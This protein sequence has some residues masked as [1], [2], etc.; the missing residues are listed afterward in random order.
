MTRADRRAAPGLLAIA[1][2]VGLVGPAPV[3]AQDRSEESCVACHAAIPDERLSVP[4][5]DWSEDVHAA[6]GFGCVACHGGD[7]QEMSLDAMDPEHGYIG[8]PEARQIPEVCGRCHSNAGFMRRYDPSIR[9]DQVAEYRTSGHGER[10]FELGDTAVATCSSCHTAHSIKPPSDPASTVHSLRVAFTCGSCH[11]DTSRMA[12]YDI[13]TDQLRGYTRSVHW[14]MMSVEGDLSAPTCNDC[15]GNHGAAPPG[16]S[17]VGNVCGQCH[18]VMAEL[19]N[20]SFHSEIFRLLGSPGCATCHGNH[21]IVRPGDELLGLGE[22]AVCSGCHS[23]GDAGGQVAAEMRSLIDSLQARR[24]HADSILARA[25]NAGMEVGEAR[26]QLGDATSALVRARNA[27]HSFDLDSV[28]ARVDDGLAV[29]EQA[30]E[31]GRAA[32]DELQFR[33]MG[34]AVSTVIILVLILGLVVKIRQLG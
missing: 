30:G 10:L 34:L 14:E 28:R 3:Q 11:S 22:E 23:A 29:T 6:R 12:R 32:L 26:F 9:V 8:V 18:S 25:E 1:L 27:V 13:P 4:A 31:R 21:E 24:R 33:R 20:A 17:W 5:V 7:G 16:V 15:H 19:F 2:A